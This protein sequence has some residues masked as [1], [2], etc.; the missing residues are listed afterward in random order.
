MGSFFSAGRIVV[1]HSPVEG[2]DILCIHFALSG[3]GPLLFLPAFSI[4]SDINDLTHPTC[5]VAAAAP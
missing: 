3:L 4:P 5:A 1:S 2:P